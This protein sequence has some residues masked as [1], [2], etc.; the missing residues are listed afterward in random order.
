MSRLIFVPQYQALM[1]YQ[2][3]WYTEFQNEFKKYFDEVITLGPIKENLKTIETFHGMFSPVKVSID[4]ELYQIQEFLR[5]KLFDDDILFL[6]DLSFPGF[7][8][9][10]LHHKRPKK[11]FAFCHATSLNAYDYFA[12]VRDSKWLVES[13][14]AK[15]FDAVFVGSYYHKKKLGWDNVIVSGVPKPPF[16]T[17]NDKK[18]IDI[19]S[20]S[21]PSIQKVNKK[22]EKKIAQN[23]G[24]IYRF[25]DHFSWAS[26]Y[27]TISNAKVVLFTGKEDT[28]GYGILE[29]VMNRSVP[30]APNNF[31]YPELLERDFLYNNL[32]EAMAAVWNGIQFP[33]QIPEIKCMDLVD[34]FYKNV[35]N[36]MKE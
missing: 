22:L 28:F 36:V 4:F 24:K 14:H 10:V 30:V 5:L 32:D 23:F 29:A 19:L 12:P 2:E 13:G 26:Y 8:T 11:M 3:W 20:V 25:P 16:Q 27:H 33:D 6:A 1:R 34:G 18:T 21:R 31:A 35:S 17:Y 7:F 9:N 15:L